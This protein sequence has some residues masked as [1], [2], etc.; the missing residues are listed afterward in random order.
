[1]RYEAA[2]YKWHHNKLK[3]KKA[4]QIIKNQA[5]SLMQQSVL[6]WFR[7]Y[8]TSIIQKYKITDPQCIWN[9]DEMNVTNIPKEQKFVSEK[10]KKLTQVVG[11][12]HAETSTIIGR[13]NTAGEKMPPLIIHKGVQVP[14]AWTH[15][16]PQYYQVRA[17]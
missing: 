14:A 7:E 3:I 9:V 10:G 2:G 13:T 5:L 12:E 16:A 15:D 1:M 4:S 17:T 11:S 8:V 6:A